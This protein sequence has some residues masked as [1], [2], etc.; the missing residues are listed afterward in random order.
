M[1]VFLGNLY[2]ESTEVTMVLLE[3]CWN[4]NQ[5]KSAG[6][7]LL[8]PRSVPLLGFEQLFCMDFAIRASKE[9][10]RYCGQDSCCSPVPL[11][12]TKKKSTR[13]STLPFYAG[14]FDSTKRRE[15]RTHFRLDLNSLGRPCCFIYARTG[16]RQSLRENVHS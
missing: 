11:S 15:R 3:G 14:L 12:A 13:F 10:G 4:R 7:V 6:S 16:A 1:L 8:F 2:Q 5:R 9:T